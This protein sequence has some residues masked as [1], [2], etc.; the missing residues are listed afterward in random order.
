MVRSWERL[1]PGLE[2]GPAARASRSRPSSSP[3][4]S[5]SDAPL[6]GAVGPGRGRRR[7]G[8]S[9]V[10]RA[11]QLHP[12]SPHRR[13]RPTRR[14]RGLTRPGRWRHRRRPGNPTFPSTNRKASVMRRLKASGPSSRPACSRPPAAPAR[15]RQRPAAR[16]P[17][18]NT[19]T[20]SNENGALWTCGFS[21]FN[22][23]D[24]AAVGRV[25]LRAAGL[26]QPAAERQDHADAGH[27]LEVGRGQQ[28]A[29]LHHPQAASSSTTA[30]PMTAGGRG[31][32]LQPAQEVPGPGPDR[33]LGGA[34]QRDPVRLRPGGHER[35]S[36]RRCRTFYYIADQTPIVP[37]HIWSKIANPV[38]Y[39]DPQ[40]GGHRP[41]QGEPVHAGEHH[42]HGQ[43]AL[44]AAR[45][46]E[47]HQGAV[48]GVHQRTTRPTTSWPT[49]RR[50]GARST[51]RRS[52]PSTRRRARTST[53]GSR[54][55]S[56]SR[57][58]RT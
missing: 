43:P 37:Q 18:T 51:S 21:P 1:R 38:T 15:R 33:G 6:I 17:A 14:E 56:T 32:H 31:V 36:T 52:S 19:V 25:R 22:G 58:C 28:V 13:Q 8:H 55:R 35:S 53:T 46:A 23:S 27:L 9:L 29:D 47:H 42:L 57:W 16:R 4:A 34:V 50:S 41:V 5:P 12:S 26:R 44:L 40:P 3:P 39:A 45:P 24:H 54:R 11:R 49:A 48:P 2:R 20:I 10:T 30:P 7:G